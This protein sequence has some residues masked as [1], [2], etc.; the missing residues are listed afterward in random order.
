[1][2][3]RLI[4]LLAL[5][6]LVCGGCRVDVEVGLD[7]RADGSGRVRVQIVADKD[8]ADAVD[9]SAGV[10]VDDLKQAGWTIEG[11]SPRKDGGVQ[12]VA[13]K[14]FSDAEGARLAVEE[15][16]GPT[17]PFQAFRLERSRSFLR[18]TTRFRGTVDFAKG[19]EAFGDPGVRSAL[20]GSD[21]G[22][23]LA[24]LEQ[25]LNGPVDKAVG[26]QVTVRLPGQVTSNAPRN[27][28]NGARWQLRL[29]DRVD[30]TAESS[31]WNVANLAG[32]ALAA[33]GIVVLLGFL[34]TRRRRR[35]TP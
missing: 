34:V 35:G 19:I 30:L 17:G 33:I 4:A 3:R 12:V 8:V 21:V 10:R 31:A 22:L 16:S 20:G 1:M 29:R 24:R 13:T 5:L 18:T 28:S 25:A 15:L 23:D 11:P 6:V 27:A 9:L 32:A 26:V 14:P 7:A 2:G